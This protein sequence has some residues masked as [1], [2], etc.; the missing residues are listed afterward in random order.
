MPGA[1]LHCERS[2]DIARVSDPRRISERVLFDSP[3]FRLSDEAFATP[4]GTITKAL[5]H[6]PGAVAVIAQ[7]TSDEVL[8]VRQ[9]RY[10]VQAWTLEIP[11]GTRTPG[12]AAAVTAA[13]ELAEETGWRAQRLSELGRFHP[14]VG[15][16][17]EEMI[18]FRAEGLTPGAAAPEPGELVRV[19]RLRLSALPAAR[20][21][22]KTLIAL[23]LLGVSTER[24]LRGSA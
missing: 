5:I 17:D 8:L 1:R 21:D 23:A 2:P 14:A 3:R 22:A 11:A 9:Y 10:S 13:R 4:D 24:L 16:S 19:E 20:Y 7:P 6:H 12:E 18:L 15:V